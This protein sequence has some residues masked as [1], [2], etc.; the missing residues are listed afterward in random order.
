MFSI[1][2]L[3]LRTGVKV[4]TIRYYENAGLLEAPERTS[5]N[6]RRYSRSGLE[7]L[8]F[9]SHAR[10]LGL[11][12]ED[13]R[14]L[15]ELASD[16]ERPCGEAHHIASAHL[17]SVRARIRKLKKLERELMRIVKI[18]DADCVGECHV[19]QSLADHALCESDH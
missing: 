12:I 9:I 16:P 13:I 4:P 2:E 1:G 6:Q 5:G 10:A 15:V 3:S 19:I 8:S 14:E 11:S 7:R 17:A 18:S